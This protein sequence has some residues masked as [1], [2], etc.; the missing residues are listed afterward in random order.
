MFD[1]FTKAPSSVLPIQIF[2]YFIQNMG[3]HFLDI[4]IIFS[5]FFEILHSIF[6]GN[7]LSFPF[8]DQSFIS[9]VKFI[10]HKCF[11][12]I[13]IRV[14]IYAVHPCL[15]RFKGFWVRY[16]KYYYHAIGLSVELIGYCFES[17][18]SSCVPDL[19]IEFLFPFLVLTLDEVNSYR[20]Y[21]CIR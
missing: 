18:L 20:L 5:R 4:Q 1:F 2:I 12:Y 14:L 7:F 3:H 11:S 15:N 17:L 10:A 6:S 8:T 13:W 21:V 9:Q 19:N 16:V